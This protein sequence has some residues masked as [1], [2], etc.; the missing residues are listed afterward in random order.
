M[1]FCK[2]TSIKRDKINNVTFIINIENI[3]V[4]FVDRQKVVFVS[5]K[6][7]VGEQICQMIIKKYILK[8][9]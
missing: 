2:I 5:T 1:T 6:E 7:L 9:I 8:R 4:K 3:H